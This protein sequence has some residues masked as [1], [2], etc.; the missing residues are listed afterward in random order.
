MTTEPNAPTGIRWMMDKG[1]TDRDTARS[2]S[3][4][5]LLSG[6]GVQGATGSGPR[7]R[8]FSTRKTARFRM[9]RRPRVQRSS[10]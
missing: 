9:P 4:T 5:A 6:N 10:V 2:F 7:G 3:V 8:P 1:W